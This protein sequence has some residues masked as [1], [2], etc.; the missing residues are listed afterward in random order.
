MAKPASALQPVLCASFCPSVCPIG[1]CVDASTREEFCIVW[2]E[3]VL[4]TGGSAEGLHG[5]LHGAKLP[6][7]HSTNTRSFTQ[8]IRF[9]PE[10]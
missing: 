10:A 2:S 3:A 5:S 6:L 1:T 7:E 4:Y 9:I 8:K